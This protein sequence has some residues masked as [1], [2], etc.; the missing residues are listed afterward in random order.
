MTLDGLKAMK[1]K[2]H[3]TCPMEDQKRSGKPEKSVDIVQIVERGADRVLT[4]SSQGK[5]SARAI[6]LQAG[7][8]YG[9]VWLSL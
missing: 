1:K 8:S 3:E 6:T 2:F 4:S 5:C 9:N 7:I